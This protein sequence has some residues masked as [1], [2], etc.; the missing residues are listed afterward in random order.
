MT[1]NVTS[2]GVAIVYELNIHH[3]VPKRNKIQHIVESESDIPKHIQTCGEGS[4]CLREATWWGPMLDLLT[5]VPYHHPRSFS[6]PMTSVNF[7]IGLTNKATRCIS[8]FHCSTSWPPNKH[9]VSAWSR[10]NAGKHWSGI[11]PTLYVCW[12]GTTPSC[13]S[14]LCS[15]THHISFLR[16]TM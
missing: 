10:A 7:Q 1:L 3:G 2:H 15:G 8:L 4:R 6:Q 14:D 16:L 9:V 12:P 13:P 5:V 11:M